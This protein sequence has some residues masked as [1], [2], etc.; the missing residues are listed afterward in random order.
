MSLGRVLAV[1]DDDSIR[2]TIRMVLTRAGYEVSTATNGQ[3]ALQ[4]MEQDAKAASV[5]TLLC[6]LDMPQV[7]GS[8]LIPQFNARY[9]LIPII[10][11]SGADAFEFTD[12]IVKQGVSDWIRKPASRDALLDKV[13]L[14]TR[15]HELRIKE[16]GRSRS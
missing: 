4:F 9:P 3:E 12:A 16:S 1:D 8:D 2:E 10:V 7:K 13:R 6:D 5:C 15:L 11:L 14:A